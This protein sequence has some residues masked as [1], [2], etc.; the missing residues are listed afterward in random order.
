MQDVYKP[1]NAILNDANDAQNDAKNTEGVNG[2][3]DAN[4]KLG[5]LKFKGVNLLRGIRIFHNIIIIARR[6]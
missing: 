2:N 5:K 3:G 4:Q 6:N 1:V